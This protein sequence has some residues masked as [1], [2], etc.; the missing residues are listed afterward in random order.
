M[1]FKDDDIKKITDTLGVD[2]KDTGNA[3]SWKL[4]NE[5]TGQ[6]LVV[7]ITN[8]VNLGKD[9]QG[10]LISVQTH[11]G[12]Y[13]L[14]DCLGYIVFDPD[15]IIFVNAKDDLISCMIIGR[16]C[17]CSMYS[18]ISRDILSA[19]F[20]SLDPAVLLSAMQLSLAEDK[21]PEIIS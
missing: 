14:H 16:Q 5:E 11:H 18:N 15:E 21:L 1:K 10:S 2:H 6:Q 20:G 9:R 7:T 4:A 8:D 3:W 13:E 12:Y 19:D 17:T